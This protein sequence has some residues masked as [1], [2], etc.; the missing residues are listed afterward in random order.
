MVRTGV[1]PKREWALITVVE[2]EMVPLCLKRKRSMDNVPSLS[3]QPTNSLDMAISVRC[4]ERIYH[5]IAAP[6]A[7]IRRSGGSYVGPGVGNPVFGCDL[8]FVGVAILVLCCVCA[9]CVKAAGK[10]RHAV[11]RSPKAGS[12]HEFEREKG[13]LTRKR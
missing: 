11:V 13:F 6:P 9:I 2:F 4:A 5:L 12:K 10:A 3:G 1:D 8:W 7:G